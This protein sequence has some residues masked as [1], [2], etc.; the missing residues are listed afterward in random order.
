MTAYRDRAE[1]PSDRDTPPPICLQAC[2]ESIGQAPAPARL[3]EGGIATE[4]LLAG[5]AVSMYADGLPLYRQEAIFARDKFELG[6]N[7]MAGWMGH[8]GFHLEPL[9]D[10]LFQL[11]RYGD[12]IFADETTLP[13]WRQDVGEPERPGCGLISETIVPMAERG[14][15]LSSIASKT[16]HRLMPRTP[17][18]R[19]AWHPPMRRLFRLSQAHGS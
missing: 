5:I 16:V 12:R 6:R 9:A 8:V 14:H 7:L 11:I 1:V 13:V 17:F 3:I 15:R 2:R 18:G 4:R 10:R 19:L